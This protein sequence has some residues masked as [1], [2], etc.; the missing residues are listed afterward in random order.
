[1]FHLDKRVIEKHA[2]CPATL[3]FA[4]QA[5]AEEVLPLG[6]E[7]LGDGRLVAHSHFVHD[8]KV[9][10]VLVPRPLQV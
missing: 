4:L 3:R 1:M 5:V 9:V 10:L 8:L 7:L 2:G 6:A